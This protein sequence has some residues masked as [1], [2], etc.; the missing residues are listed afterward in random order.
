MVAHGLISAGL[1]L[2]IVLSLPLPLYWLIYFID[3]LA[4]RMARLLLIHQ[5]L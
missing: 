3:D 2:L 4:I 1:F 5:V